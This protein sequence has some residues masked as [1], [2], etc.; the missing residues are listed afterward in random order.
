M[1]L[2]LREDG[3]FICSTSLSSQRRGIEGEVNILKLLLQLANLVKYSFQYSEN[4]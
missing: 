3:E 2:P 4:N 1:G